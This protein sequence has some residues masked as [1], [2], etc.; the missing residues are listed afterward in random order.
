MWIFIK[1]RLNSNKKFKM[2]IFFIEDIDKLNGK[3]I[4][5][6]SC[7]NFIFEENFLQIK[8]MIKGIVINFET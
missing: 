7:E 6:K 8:N 5:G 3:K 1:L 4:I 2:L